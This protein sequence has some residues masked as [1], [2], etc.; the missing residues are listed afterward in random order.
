MAT[1]ISLDHWGRVE[2]LLREDWSPEQI[3]LWLAQTSRL[4]ISHEWIYQY[5]YRDKRQGDSIE[6]YPSI[7]VSHDDFLR[8]V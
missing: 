6:G 7:M 4:V 8:V 3:S 5:I 1:R 2:I